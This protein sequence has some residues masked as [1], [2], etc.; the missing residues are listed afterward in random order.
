M[1]DLAAR[2]GLTWDAIDQLAL[3]L[4]LL[5]DP[6]PEVGAVAKDT[7]EAIPRAVLAACLARPET[8]SALRAAFGAR[9]VEPGPV[10]VPD[11]APPPV[12]VD[13]ES[14]PASVN[15]A[16]PQVLAGLPVTA[17]RWRSEA[18]ANSGPCSCGIRT[19]SSRSR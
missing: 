2:G 17:S 9:G 12:P 5:D 4:F 10:P 14:E 6:A 1:R 16:R 8:T 15:E 18:H 11:D 7:L 13:T 3:L 19:K